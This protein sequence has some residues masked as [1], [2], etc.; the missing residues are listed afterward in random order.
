MFGLTQ[1]RGSF[2]LRCDETG[3]FLAGVP[4]LR[5]TGN[6]FEARP[7]AELN[8]VLSSAYRS[9]DDWSRQTAGIGAI[10]RALN[11]DDVSLA[12]IAAVF[13]KLQKLDWDAAVRIAGLEDRLVK[14]GFNP[15]EPRNEHGE[16]TSG[17]DEGDEHR[18]LPDIASDKLPL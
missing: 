15:N 6:R 14:G 7:T 9:G 8:K 11:E 13:L 12:M 10:A 17:L 5:R 18:S 1:Q 3:L 2:G 4:L 16:W